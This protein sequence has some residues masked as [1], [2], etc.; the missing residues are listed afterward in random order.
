[1]NPCFVTPRGTTTYQS[2]D[3]LRAAWTDG[4]GFRV[5]KFGAIITKA[6]A[7][8]LLKAKFTHVK[9]VWQTTEHVTMSYDLELKEL[10]P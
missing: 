10:P 6:D 2:V 7:N 8:R 5:Y 9:F 4:A 3:E 1:M